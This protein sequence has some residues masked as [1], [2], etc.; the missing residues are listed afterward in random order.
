MN[1][2][3]AK[4]K[5]LPIAFTTRMPNASNRHH[6]S[7]GHDQWYGDSP[8]AI[9]DAARLPVGAD[10]GRYADNNVCAAMDV[11]IVNHAGTPGKSGYLYVTM[12]NERIRRKISRKSLNKPWS[13][14]PYKTIRRMRRT[15]TYSSKKYESRVWIQTY[16]GRIKYAKSLGVII[17]GELKSNLYGVDP[18]YVKRLIEAAR[19]QN[20]PPWYMA[21]SNMPHVMHKAKFT[22]TQ[23]G[24]FAV[25]ARG[26]MPKDFANWK[27]YVTEVYGANWGG[28]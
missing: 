28:K 26:S 10:G 2:E 5:P 6:P 13:Q 20:T 7:H 19:R 8:R 16:E 11:D 27:R 23:N 21:L 14:Y 3:L 24:Q 12:G 17:Y 4:R 9:E 18:K 22:T 1:D 25:L 15:R